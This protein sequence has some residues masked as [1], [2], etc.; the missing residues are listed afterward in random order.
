MERYRKLPTEQSCP[1]EDWF[2]AELPTG[3]TFNCIGR[4]VVELSH[5]ERHN[6]QGQVKNLSRALGT[7]KEN[8]QAIANSIKVKG[9]LLTAQ[10]PFLT[11]DN[12]LLDGFTR[13]DAFTLIGSTHWVFNIVEPKEGFT[14]DDVREEVGLGANDH[15]PCKS[16]TRDDFSKALARWIDRQDKTPTQ[17]ECIDWVDS[18]PHSFTNAVVANLVEKTLKSTASKLSMLSFQAPDVIKKV[19]EEWVEN[20]PKSTKV[21]AVNISGNDTYFKRVLCE[22]AAALSSKK[23]DDTLV[24]GY[25]KD[26]PAEDVDEVRLEG[27]ETIQRINDQFETLFQLRMSKGDSFKF[28]DLDYFAPQKVGEEDELIVP[29][30]S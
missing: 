5:I 21:L 4:R 9:V 25:T 12:E 1:K 16:A 15:P 19:K 24:V 27:L 26:V 29:V 20:V 17:G 28:I 14:L 13:F 8:F 2:E 10:L 22:R 7:S 6:S 18:I 23:Y 30:K 11:V 3:R